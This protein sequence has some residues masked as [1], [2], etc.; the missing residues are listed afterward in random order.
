MRC[1]LLGRCC[2]AFLCCLLLVGCVG[3]LPKTLPL[4]PLESEEA[5]QLWSGL[6]TRVRPQALDADI[7]LTWD[8]LGSKGG[9]GAALLVQQPGLLRCT[10]NDPLGRSLVMAVA[11][12]HSFTLI[13]NQKGQVYQGNTRSSF[14]QKYVPKSIA[15]ADLLS[16][17]GGLLP[18]TAPR[19]ARA[20]RDEA[21]Q[22]FWYQWTDTQAMRHHVLVDRQDK[23]I[24]QHLLFDAQGIVMLAVQYA[25][26]QQGDVRGAKGANEFAWPHT[27]Q[28]SGQ[29]LKGTLNI[30]VEKVYSHLPQKGAAAFR[31]PPHFV[32]EQ[33]P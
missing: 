19:E 26:Y 32:V 1:L 13:D 20:D 12:A 2:V 7:R 22:G 5:A 15:V 33:V 29:A 23:S 9:V 6:I 8:F 16:L 25:E 3:K 31:L 21:D 10:V 4:A 24:Q 11:D 14:W 28:M 27:V 30:Q 17:L 18:E